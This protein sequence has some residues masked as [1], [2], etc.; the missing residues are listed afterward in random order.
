MY[1]LVGEECCPTCGT[2]GKLMRTEPDVFICPACSAVFG[3]FGVV[4][5][6]EQEREMLL[7]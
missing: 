7:S 6:P 3:E 1:M 4:L 2:R 5:E